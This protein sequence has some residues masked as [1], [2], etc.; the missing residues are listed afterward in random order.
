MHFFKLKKN[1]N[2]VEVFNETSPKIELPEEIID[3]LSL[4]KK[5]GCG[6]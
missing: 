1:Y 3:L 2:R 6:F 4:G 5:R